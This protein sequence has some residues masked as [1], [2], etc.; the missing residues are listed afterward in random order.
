VT[1]AE[2]LKADRRAPQRSCIVTREVCDK[3]EL[4][5]FVAAPDGALIPDVAGKLPGRGLWVKADAEILQRAVKE[6]RFAKAARQQVELPDD[7]VGMTA[8]LLEARVMQSLALARKAGQVIQ[9]FDKV[10][11]AVQ[12]GDA[13]AVLH[14][15]DA[16]EDGRKKLSSDGVWS[17]ATL[18]REQLSRICGVENATHVALLRGGGAQKMLEELRR[19][20][21]FMGKSAL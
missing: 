15:S 3:A 16:A 18:S 14:A 4:I 19:F 6:K 8:G 9:G 2:T 12:K 11:H 13:L 10:K 17:D 7:L 1:E 20:T 5:R 21:G